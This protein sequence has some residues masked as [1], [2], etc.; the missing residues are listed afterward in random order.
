MKLKLNNDADRFAW[1]Q[2]AGL[3]NSRSLTTT[4][5]EYIRTRA[6]FNDDESCE[7]TVA[8]A[9]LPDSYKGNPS[10]MAVKLLQKLDGE[11]MD[12]SGYQTP[13]KRTHVTLVM[14]RNAKPSH[15][16]R[17]HASPSVK[18]VI[19]EWLELNEPRSSRLRIPIAS[20]PPFYFSHPEQLKY[21]I[22]QE[23]ETPIK[24]IRLSKSWLIARK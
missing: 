11:W 14:L 3:Q 20:V 22:K 6:I 9:L 23:T 12:S 24:I 15:S 18:Q 8:K 17:A 1:E 7:V 4:I 21:Q 5:A 2:V 13:G 16:R 10:L 19:K